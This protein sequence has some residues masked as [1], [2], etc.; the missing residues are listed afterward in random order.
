M[1]RDTTK[2]TKLEVTGDLTVGGAQTQAG[3]QT[4]SADVTVATDKKIQFRDT[5]LFINSGAD[6]KMTISAD[7]V[8][9]DDINLA[10]SVAA[11]DNIR[12]ATDKKVEFRDAGLFIH[13]NA[14]GKLTIS[15]DGVGADDIALSG[16][17]ALDAALALAAAGFTMAAIA[18]TATVDGTTTGTI[19]SGPMLQFIAVTSDDA[20]KIIVLPAPTPGSIVIL[21]VA[22]TGYELRSSD[23]ATVAINGGTGA[24]AESA[25]GANTTLLMI[26]ASATSWKGL[27]LG[28]DGTLA[29]VEAAA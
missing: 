29:Q 26:C 25:I 13:S 21:H 7:G 12:M 4:F 3:A 1:A 28:S 17:V 8:G 6:G 18:R 22:A 9:A 15:A 19:A 20:N 2:L 24:T 14:D 5:G 23:P 10:G 11:A 16:T 27:Q